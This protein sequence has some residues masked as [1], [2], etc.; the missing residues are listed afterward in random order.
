M[1]VLPPTHGVELI[2][3]LPRR[4]P[5]AWRVPAW[6]TMEVSCLLLA[7]S[8][9]VFV[10]VGWSTTRDSVLLYI[11]CVT[12]QFGGSVI[13]LSTLLNS[14]CSGEAVEAEWCSPC[15]GR[16]FC[17]EG[18][19]SWRFRNASWWSCFQHIIDR[20]NHLGTLYT[21]VWVVACFAF[22]SWLLFAFLVMSHRSLRQAHD[23]S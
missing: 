18:Q 8:D 10:P 13:S 7:D 16:W 20:V 12:V 19:V 22:H 5:V 3:A 9:S 6:W 1:G 2:S 17:V 11:N 23:G 21:F 4:L 14:L 15:S